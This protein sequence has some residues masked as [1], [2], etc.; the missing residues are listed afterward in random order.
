MHPLL[1]DYR[2]LL[3]Y[4]LAWLAAG[5]LLGAMLAMAEAAPWRNALLFALPVCL[6]YGFFALSAYYL[7]RALPLA[8]R[9]AYTVVLSYSGASLAAGCTWLA[10]CYTWNDLLGNLGADWAAITVS[11]RL[12]VALFAAGLVTY[13]LSLLVHDVLIAFESIWAAER[14]EA[15]ARA[16]A[17][18]AE[19]QVLRAQID[20]HFLFNSLNSISALTSL[21]ADAAR[22]MTISLAEFFRHTL[23]LSGRSSI[24]FAEEMTLCEHFLAVE[25]IR[26]GERLRTAIHVDAAAQDALLPA[27][28]LQPLLENALKHGIRNLSEGGLISVTVR[29]T[30]DRLSIAMENPVDTAP[31]PASDNGVGLKN[32]RQRLQA[33]YGERAQLAWRRTEDQRFVVALSI[34]YERNAHA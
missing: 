22:A 16:L 17:R 19:L 21:D 32:L 28:S 9:D 10:L 18:E 30:G 7:C 1:A 24:T 3:C 14:R 12:L 13:L 27:L 26:F 6:A 11:R 23:A 8:R 4:F 33:L 34:P 15:E 5:T 31:T 20:P 25:K 29:V 2:K